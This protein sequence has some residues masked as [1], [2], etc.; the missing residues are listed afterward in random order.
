MEIKTGRTI[1]T[2]TMNKIHKTDKGIE[3]CGKKA[4]MTAHIDGRDFYSYSYK[5]ECGNEIC[6]KRKRSKSDMMYW[7]DD[8]E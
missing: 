4:K 6:I 1:V 3:C 7:G 8:F 5:C 2:D